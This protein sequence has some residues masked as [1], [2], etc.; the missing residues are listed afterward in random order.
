MRSKTKPNRDLPT[1]FSRAWRRL[2]VF[3]LISDWFIALFACAVI[4]HSNCLGFGSTTLD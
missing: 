2:H 4:G 3:A 1:A